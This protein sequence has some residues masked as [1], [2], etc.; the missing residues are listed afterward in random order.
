MP[1]PSTVD[2]HSPSSAAAIKAVIAHYT[3]RVSSS[4]QSGNNGVAEWIKGKI[5]EDLLRHLSEREV[6]RGLSQ[7]GEGIAD[8]ATF[9]ITRLSCTAYDS[10]IYLLS[11]RSAGEGEEDDRSSLAAPWLL[12]SLELLEGNKG[13]AARGM[14]V[15]TDSRR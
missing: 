2:P 10:G 14:K 13:E 15:C 7:I 1:I 8:S 12:W 3:A 4:V 6:R 5:K 11:R 9:Q